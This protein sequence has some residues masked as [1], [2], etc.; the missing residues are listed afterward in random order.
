MGLQRL[1]ALWLCRAIR[2]LWPDRNPLRRR[3]DRLE[4]YLLGGLLVAATAGGPF[5]VR[6]ATRDAYVT[7]QRARQEQLATVH[8]VPATLSVPASAPNG[9]AVGSSVLAQASWTSAN[10]TRHSGLVPVIPGS[11]RGTSVSVWTDASGNLSSP[12]LTI[13]EVTGQADA[14]EAATIIVIVV[15]YGAGAVAIRQLTN[16]RRMAA[17]DEDWLI[18]AQSWNHHQS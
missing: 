2:G 12:P 5:A 4:V 13:S 17:W 9:Y 15:G 8:Q 16:R 18:T 6:A 3:T 7:A 10:G 1:Q 11:P 14:A